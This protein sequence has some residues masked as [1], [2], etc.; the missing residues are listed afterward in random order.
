MVSDAQSPFFPWPV[1]WFEIKMEPP[2]WG[3]V[4]TAENTDQPKNK[5]PG[6]ATSLP[7]ADKGPVPEIDPNFGKNGPGQILNVKA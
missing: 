3:F 5:L 2:P 6:F 7:N 4:R 1:R